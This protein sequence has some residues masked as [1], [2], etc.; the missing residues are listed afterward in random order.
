MN[1]E[2]TAPDADPIV[3]KWVWFDGSDV[4]F[5]SDKK[6]LSVGKKKGEWKQGR[7]NYKGKEYS[8][9]LIWDSGFIDYLN[10][11]NGDQR[12]EGVN[13]VGSPIRGDRR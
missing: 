5:S 1:V 12:L 7:F 11:V 2:I 8:Y 10:L 6:I 13:T 4:V 3:G 9:N